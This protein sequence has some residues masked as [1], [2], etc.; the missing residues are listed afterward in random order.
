MG[1]APDPT[2]H[3]CPIQGVGCYLQHPIQIGTSLLST[4]NRLRD[5]RPAGESLSLA[6]AANGVIA[7]KRRGQAGPTVATQSGALPPPPRP[8]RPTWL[9]PCTPSD[10]TM[11]VDV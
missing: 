9:Y 4:L 1:V 8:N 11:Q 7:G 3:L 10:R 6:A 5:L 2:S